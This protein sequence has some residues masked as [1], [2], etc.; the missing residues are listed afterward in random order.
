MPNFLSW[1]EFFYIL[2]KYIF[3]R[4]KIQV[5][6]MEMRVLEEQMKKDIF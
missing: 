1:E 2:E 3:P 5:F 4:Y 6:E